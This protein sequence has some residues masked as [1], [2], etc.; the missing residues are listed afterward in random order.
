MKTMPIARCSNKPSSKRSKLQEI[1]AIIKKNSKFKFST[2]ST[3]RTPCDIRN[4]AADVRRVSKEEE[5]DPVMII[6][7]KRTTAPEIIIS[8]AAA[9][10]DVEEKASSRALMLKT[11][12]AD[13]IF[14]ATHHLIG[15]SDGGVA[16]QKQMEEKKLKEEGI[17]IADLKKR[18]E[19]E[20]VARENIKKTVEFN[21]QNRDVMNQLAMWG[22]G[23]RW[24]GVGP[25]K[26]LGLFIKPDDFDYI[27]RHPDRVDAVLP[28]DDID[29]EQGEIIS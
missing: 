25:L 11:R 26:K 13:T 21:D 17:R 6:P 7:A 22:C 16:L 23:R 3:L 19:R 9:E 8:T 12:F 24:G 28:I 14:K 29:I 20:R 15:K 27:E 1:S 2:T 5:E 10:D 4:T 18:R